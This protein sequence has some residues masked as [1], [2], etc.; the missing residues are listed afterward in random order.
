MKTA[1]PLEGGTEDLRVEVAEGARVLARTGMMGYCGRDSVFDVFGVRGGLFA[2]GRRLRVCAFVEAALRR[3]GLEVKIERDPGSSHR[4]DIAVVYQKPAMW[5]TA[6]NLS[7]VSS[8]FT[9]F[10]YPETLSM[11]SKHRLSRSGTSG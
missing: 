10:V 8:V 5:S 7:D 4:I 6:V 2:L 11:R 9:S 1:G 3:G